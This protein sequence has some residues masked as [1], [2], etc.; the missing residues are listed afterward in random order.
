MTKHLLIKEFI[1]SQT[2]M[3]NLENLVNLM[4][5]DFK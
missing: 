1:H 5:K 4:Q 2:L 3:E